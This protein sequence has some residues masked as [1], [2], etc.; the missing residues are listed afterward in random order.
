MSLRNEYKS[1]GLIITNRFNSFNLRRNV[2]LNLLFVSNYATV[3][4]SN[5]LVFKLI[6]LQ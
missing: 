3:F 2:L 5:K 1:K 4:H 6:Y